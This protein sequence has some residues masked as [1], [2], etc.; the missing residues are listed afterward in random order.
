MIAV[1][2]TVRVV[3]EPMKSGEIDGKLTYRHI[4]LGSGQIAFTDDIHGVDDE[5][6]DD[7]DDGNGLG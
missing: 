3:A 2:G 6:D 1:S 4:V 5:G 7:D